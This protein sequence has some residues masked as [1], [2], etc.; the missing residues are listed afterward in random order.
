MKSDVI[1]ID[2]RGNGFDKSLDET[3]K[4]AA[5]EDLTHKESLCLQPGQKHY[6]RNEGIL[7]D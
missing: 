4:V 5:Y 2:N 7:L 6:R 1:I 3:R